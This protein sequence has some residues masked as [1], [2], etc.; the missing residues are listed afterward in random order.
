MKKRILM[1]SAVALFVA[2][3]AFAA[4]MSW[5]RMSDQNCGRCKMNDT[6]R[7]CGRCGGFMA[8]KG[9]ANYVPGTRAQYEEWFECNDCHHQSKWR[10]GY[11]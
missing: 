8:S 1:S 5:E 9:G 11:K 2:F 10:Y 3:A 4:G 7:V 6:E